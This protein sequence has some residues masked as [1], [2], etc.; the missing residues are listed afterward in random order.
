MMKNGVMVEVC[1]LSGMTDAE[2][3]S[4]DASSVGKVVEFRHNGQ[5]ADSYRHPRWYRLRPDKNPQDCLWI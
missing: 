2:R 1:K 4:L 5:T 3:R